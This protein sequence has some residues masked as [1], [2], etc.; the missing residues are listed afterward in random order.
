MKNKYNSP[1]LKSLN[2]FVENP[3]ENI[4]LREFAR[5]LN[6]S[7]NSAQRFLNLFLH[8]NFIKEE[9]KANLRYFRANLDSIVFRY[10]KITFSLKLIENSG[11]IS[12]F[13]EICSHL[14][15][16]GSVA[17]GRDDKNSDIDIIVIAKDKETI[18]RIIPKIQKKISREINFQIFT[19]TE[20]RA[21]KDKNKAFYQE[22]IIT[23]INL[24]GEIPI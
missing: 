20:W 6:I 13:K 18:K 19:T 4:H 8:Q 3:Y 12:S 15:L 22:I 16:F 7:V 17:Q 9:R 21:Q 14:I 23:G 11:L 5:R 10:I 24:I 1:I 2:F